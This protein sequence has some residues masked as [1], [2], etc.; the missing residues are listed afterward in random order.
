MLL[1]VLGF[2]A[3]L[4]ALY[5]GAEFLVGGSSSLALRF[6]I[7]PLIVGLTV[8]AFGTSAPELLVSLLAVFDG[9][10][11]FCGASYRSKSPSH[12]FYQLFRGSLMLM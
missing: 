6:G 5:F 12:S 9:S 7:A 3:G 2:L 4:V 10:C 11:I 1:T 8:V